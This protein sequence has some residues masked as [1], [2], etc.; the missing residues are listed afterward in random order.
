MNFHADQKITL[1]SDVLFREVCGESVLLDLSSE[2]YFGLNEVGT[3]IWELLESGH[4]VGETLEVLTG[5]FEV[6]RSVAESDFEELLKRLVSAGLVS[7]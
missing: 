2:N 5:E 1:S 4:S 7:V 3:R 6:E